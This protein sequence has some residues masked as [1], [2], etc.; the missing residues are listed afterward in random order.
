MVLQVHLYAQVPERT[1]RKENGGRKHMT[2]EEKAEYQKKYRAEHLE[3]IKASRRYYYQQ[4]REKLRS[5]QKQYRELHKE[6]FRERQKAYYERHKDDPEFKK[7][8][9]EN[10]KFWAESNREKIN[11][12]QRE[13]YRKR[14]LAEIVKERE[15]KAVASNG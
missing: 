15:R 12:K 13:R 5:Y 9:Y 8:N 3:E 11:A 7:K 6:G 10:Y 1:Q 14:K 2:K 4:N